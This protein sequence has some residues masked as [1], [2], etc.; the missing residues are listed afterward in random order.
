[1]SDLD[2]PAGGTSS[3]EVA[4][5]VAIARAVQAERF[6]NV[7]TMHLNADAEGTVLEE[8]AAPDEEGRSFLLKAAGKFGLTA[9]GYHRILRVARTIADLAGSSA[10]R[11]PHI[12]EAVSFRVNGA[13]GN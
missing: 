13:S 1:L 2:L 12:A 10:V 6:A 7:T 5:N 3:A 11:K 4:Q 8:I 9:R